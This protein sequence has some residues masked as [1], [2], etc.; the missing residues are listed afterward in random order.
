MGDCLVAGGTGDVESVGWNVGAEVTASGF[1]VTGES[2]YDGEALGSLLLLLLVV[3]DA[4]NCND[5]L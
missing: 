2:Y 1:S 4:F 5:M 3:L